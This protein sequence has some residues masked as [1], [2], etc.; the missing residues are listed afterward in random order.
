MQRA[1]RYALLG[2]CSLAC[3]SWHAV[4]PTPANYLQH[5]TPQEIRL[6][7]SDRSKVV[8]RNPIMVGDTL[9]GIVGPGLARGDLAHQ[10]AIPM[11]D[12]R[13]IAVREFSTS[14]TLGVFILGTLLLFGSLSQGCHDLLC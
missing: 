4:R 1:P 7:R 2:L 14:K 9:R 3:T 5:K 6:I 12:I 10:I 13:T 11:N 8:V